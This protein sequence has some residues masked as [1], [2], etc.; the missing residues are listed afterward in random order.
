MICEAC[1]NSSEG[2]FSIFHYGEEINLCQN[3]AQN[4]STV[5]RAKHASTVD[6][7]KTLKKMVKDSDQQDVID[8]IVK[9]YNDF[10]ENDNYLDEIV[11][12]VGPVN[13]PIYLYGLY[14]RDTYEIKCSHD[15]LSILLYLDLVDRMRIMT[16]KGFVGIELGGK[17]KSLGISHDLRKNHRSFCIELIKKITNIQKNKEG[18]ICVE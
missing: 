7:S 16:P 13:H 17:E 8:A 5:V 2:I 18:E 4:L 3:C 12:Q 1:L 14:D 9:Q 11:L 6:I 10:N 15:V